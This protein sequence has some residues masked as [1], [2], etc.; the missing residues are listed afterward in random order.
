MCVRACVCVC[1]NKNQNQNQ[2]QVKE[3]RRV[4][5]HKWMC[6]RSRLGPP[7]LHIQR[8]AAAAEAVG[9]SARSLTFRYVRLNVAEGE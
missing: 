2:N 4:N 9:Q 5:Q 3:G 7:L 6:P 1:K 8:K